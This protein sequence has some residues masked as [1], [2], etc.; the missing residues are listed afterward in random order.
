M[1]PSGLLPNVAVPGGLPSSSSRRPPQDHRTL[2][3]GCIRTTFFRFFCPPFFRLEFRLHFFT[4]LEL[5]YLHFCSKIMQNHSRNAPRSPTPSRDRFFRIPDRFPT[6]ANIGFRAGAYKITPPARNRRFRSAPNSVRIFHEKK[7]PFFIQKIIKNTSGNGPDTIPGFC[8]LFFSFFHDFYL[9][10]GALFGQNAVAML[11]FYLLLGAFFR[12][13][14][15]FVLLAG[16]F[17]VRG[18][19]GG[20]PDPFW[21]LRSRPGPHFP[22]FLLHFGSISGHSPVIWPDSAGS[23]AGPDS[24]PFLLHFRPALPQFSGHFAGLC[25]DGAGLCRDGAGVSSHPPVRIL[26]G[27]SG[28]RRCREAV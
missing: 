6:C 7:T 16:I 17:V 1:N 8:H 26:R 3:G 14:S 9:L 27:D 2:A 20:A 28:V 23:R 5:F 21:E 4:F 25:R 18:S 13:F 10:F 24:P 12:V 19:S 22:P 11:F 15:L